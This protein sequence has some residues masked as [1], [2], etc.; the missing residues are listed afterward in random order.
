MNKVYGV[1][2]PSIALLPFASVDFNVSRFN[3]MLSFFVMTELYLAADFPNQTRTS[4]GMQARLIKARCERYRER[5]GRR[6]RTLAAC[7]LTFKL[8]P[9]WLATL[10]R[11]VHEG[12]GQASGVEV[13]WGGRMSKGKE[14]WAFFLVF[15]FFKLSS[16]KYETLTFAKTSGWTERK[17][18]STRLTFEPPSFVFT[19]SHKTNSRKISRMTVLTVSWRCEFS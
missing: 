2:Y 10:K 15:V 12:Y 17:K 4:L 19:R 7:L 14:G 13:V 9:L 11:S 1:L 6:E 18:K 16:R 5:G 8:I 3:T